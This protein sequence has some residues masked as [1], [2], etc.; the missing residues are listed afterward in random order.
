METGQTDPEVASSQSVCPGTTEPASIVM[1]GSGGSLGMHMPG[2]SGRPGSN[3][4]EEQRGIKNFCK[5]FVMP[6]FQAY[7]KCVYM[8][9]CIC[10]WVCLSFLEYVCTCMLILTCRFVCMYKYS[11]L[12]MGL[13]CV[14]LFT[15]AYILA[16]D[17]PWCM[18]L[19]SRQHDMQVCDVT[20]PMYVSS[21]DKEAILVIRASIKCV[22]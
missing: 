9:V 21:N 13:C 6:I 14:C 3:R 12:F 15:P 7:I 11:S 22:M 16:S 2:S 8:Y 18:L 17:M 20:I 1:P 5:E 10:V 19:R 4:N